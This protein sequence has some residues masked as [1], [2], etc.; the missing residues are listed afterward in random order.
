MTP[1]YFFFDTYIGY[2]LQVLPAALLAGLLYGIRRFARDKA[3]PT[4]RKIWASLLISYLT[5]LLCL[6]LLIKVIG[7]LWYFLLYHQPSGIIYHWFDGEFDLVPDFFARFSR[8]NLGNLLMYLPFGFLHP[9]SRDHAGW[10]DTLWAGLVLI[11]AI[12]LVQPV[13]GRSFDANDVILNFTGVLLSTGLFFLG[14]RFIST[15]HA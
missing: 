15:K 8:E 7:S 5:G 9:L 6:T 2:F 11:L 10:R 13:V 14:R 3:S 4:S 1:Q 12:E